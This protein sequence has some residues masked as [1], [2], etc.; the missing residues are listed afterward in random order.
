MAFLWPVLAFCVRVGSGGV[1]VSR[2]SESFSVY[3]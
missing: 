1:I 2:L 3:V